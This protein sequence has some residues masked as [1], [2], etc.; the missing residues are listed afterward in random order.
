MG[1]GELTHFWDV[2]EKAG[3]RMDIASPEGGYVPIDPESL[4]A[5]VL[6]EAGTD[7]R[8]EDRAFMDLLKDTMKVADADPSSYDAIYM[9]GGH[10][11]CFD[12]PRSDEL[13]KLT[14]RFYEA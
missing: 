3:C 8:Y 2:A 14:A 5:A 9:T 11:V 7:R 12:F 13:A 1:L 6:K 10:G 4:A